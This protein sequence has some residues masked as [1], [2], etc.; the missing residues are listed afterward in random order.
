MINR[1]ARPTIAGAAAGLSA[2]LFLAAIGAALI[3]GMPVP[4]AL[5]SVIGFPTAF[6]AV[7]GAGVGL[8]A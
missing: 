7:L 2:G 4:I 8:E 6:G 5:A 3:N 1:L